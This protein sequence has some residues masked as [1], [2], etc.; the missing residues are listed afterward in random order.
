VLD[1]ALMLAA[2][3]P[4]VARNAAADFPEGRTNAPT[5]LGSWIDV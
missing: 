2:N 3:L 5:A 1:R 4:N